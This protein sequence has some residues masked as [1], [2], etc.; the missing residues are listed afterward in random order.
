MTKIIAERS[1]GIEMRSFHG[2]A[3]VEAAKDLRPRQQSIWDLSGPGRGRRVAVGPNAII[4]DVAPD[5]GVFVR[6][7]SWDGPP[8]L[9]AE[10][11]TVWDGP[12]F[13]ASGRVCAVQENQGEKDYCPAFDLGSEMTQWSAR[14][15][16]KFVDNDREPLFPRDIYEVTLLTLQLWP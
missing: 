2:F 13:L 5:V 15:L 7:E 11:E 14:L 12:L 8:D 6:Y 9:Y 16:S 3:D 4:V 1:D 10:W